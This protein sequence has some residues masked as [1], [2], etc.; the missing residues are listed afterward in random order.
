M[1]NDLLPL[2]VVSGFPRTGTSTMMRMLHFGGMEVLTEQDRQHGKHEFDPYGNYELAG[3]N[4][5]RF[6]EWDPE[7]TYNKAVKIV[8]PFIPEVCPIDRP[9]KV[10]FMLRDHNEIIASLLAMRVVWE[11]SPSEGVK[12]ARDFLEEHDIPTKYVQ[13]ADMLTYPRSTA[14]S[15]ADWIGLNIDDTTLTHMASAVD[16][17]ARTRIKGKGGQKRLVTY[18]FDRALVDDRFVVDLKEENQNV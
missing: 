11:W 1:P 5:F 9:V 14:Q 13:Y 10:I 18:K 4:L 6:R 17:K 8:A 12:Y 7:D 16:K 3:E 15:V 2:I